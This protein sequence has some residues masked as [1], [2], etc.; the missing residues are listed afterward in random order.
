LLE[1]TVMFATA[2]YHLDFPEFGI[3]CYVT[4]QLADNEIVA[5]IIQ[6]LG[7]YPIG[8]LTIPIDYP[9]NLPVNEYAINLGLAIRE[10]QMHQVRN[11]PEALL[12][13]ELL[14]VETFTANE[15]DNE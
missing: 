12:P 1:Q 9:D 7:P 2:R 11:M 15:I 3:K 5:G 4:G 13:E 14:E 10:S 8:S 6:D